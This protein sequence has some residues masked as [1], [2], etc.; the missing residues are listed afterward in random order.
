VVCATDQYSQVKAASPLSFDL[1][2]IDDGDLR[3]GREMES[4]NS[5]RTERRSTKSLTS[6]AS[7]ALD[8]GSLQANA[9][10]SLLSPRSIC[11]GCKAGLKVSLSRDIGIEIEL[12]TSDIAMCKFIC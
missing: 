2:I 4:E 10:A 9:D 6:F 7:V 3:G 8:R 5:R 1:I 11:S 12:M